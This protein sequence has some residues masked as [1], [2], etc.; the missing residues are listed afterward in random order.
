MV[1]TSKEIISFPSIFWF[2]VD[3]VCTC[4][5]KYKLLKVFLDHGARGEKNYSTK[6]KSIIPNM[7]IH[8]NTA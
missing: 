5:V 2:F 4:I 8:T 3:Y 6:H 1:K 7:Y